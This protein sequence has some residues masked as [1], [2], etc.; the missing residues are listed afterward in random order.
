LAEKTTENSLDFK[1][2]LPVLV[3]VL[4]DILGLTILIP[5]LPYYAI[6]FGADAL[7]IGLLG[8]SYPAMQFLFVPILGSLSDRIGRKPVLAAAQVGTFISLLILG[9]SGAL[10]VI[11]LSRILDGITGANLATAQSVITDSTD[12]ENRARGLGLIGATFGV[13]FLIGPVLSGLALWL[14]GNNYSA[15][16]FLAAGFAFVSVLLTTFMLKETHPPEKRGVADLSRKRN[17][18]RMRDYMFHPTLG[19][20]FLFVFLNQVIFGSFQMTFAPF[21]LNKLGLNSLGNVIFFGVFGIF[22]AVMQGGLA[23]PLN[24]RFG[25]QKL[26]FTGLFIFATGFFLTGFTPTQPVSWYSREAIIAEFQQGSQATT[27]EGVAEQLQ[28]LPPENIEKGNSALYYMIATMLFVPIGFGMLSPNISSLLTKRADPA[29]IGE[30]LGVAAAFTALGSVAGP[31]A[32]GVIFDY[33]G[34]NWVF[35]I[36]GVGAYILLWIMW[37]KLKPA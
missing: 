17:F 11:F 25:E 1:K 23:G 15:P 26:V 30:V 2:L 36:G 10:W 6:A 16:A 5:V 35:L 31:L 4:V 18:G 9:F 34:P 22:S 37:L 13:G 7:T 19:V 20:L 21:T 28:L 27:E 33:L 12:E 3:V 29:K 14:S 8:A 32:G 24:K